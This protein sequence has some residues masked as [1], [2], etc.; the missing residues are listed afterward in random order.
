MLLLCAL[1]LNSCELSP[2]TTK[3][4]SGEYLYMYKSGEIESWLLDDNSTYKQ[5]LFHDRKNYELRTNSLYKN[6]GNWSLEKDHV[7][8]INTLNF[9]DFSK[10]G[11]VINQ[12]QHLTF[13]SGVWVAPERGTDAKIFI[14][15]DIGYVLLRVSTPAA[16]K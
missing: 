3:E 9:F 8:M 1:L 13:Q 15:E 12:P 6:F 11:R 5:E 7:T 14:A 2:L 16:V 10:Q 4:V